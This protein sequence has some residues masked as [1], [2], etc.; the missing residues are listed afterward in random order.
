MANVKLPAK[1]YV[2]LYAAT[3]FT[4]G[5]QIC[6]TNLTPDQVRVFDTASEPTTS[7]DFYPCTWRHA[8][9]KNTGGDAGAWA[10]SV[11]GG[12]VD[13]KEVVA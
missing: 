11:T 8:P 5:A 10:Y 2:D 1:T 6:V 7:D 9:V 12:A 4:V 13:V 3:G